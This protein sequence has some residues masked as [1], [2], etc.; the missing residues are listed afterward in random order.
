MFVLGCDFAAVLAF[1][2]AAVL[3][4]GLLRFWCS[5]VVLIFVSVMILL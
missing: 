4:V 1:V 2:S 5:S 3:A